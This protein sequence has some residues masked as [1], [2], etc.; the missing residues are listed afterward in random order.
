MSPLTSLACALCLTS[1]GAFSAFA[2]GTGADGQVKIFNS[3]PGFTITGFYT[4]DGSGWTRDWLGHETLTPGEGAV[5]QF[6]SA[7]PTCHQHVR[8]GWR[9]ASGHEFRGHAIRVNICGLSN[10]YF[11][12]E[13]TYFD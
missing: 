8:A 2:E 11:A 7:P 5:A 1:L 13:E 12:Q 3:S 10:I 6:R 4:N 9:S